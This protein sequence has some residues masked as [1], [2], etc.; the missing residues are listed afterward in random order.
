MPNQTTNSFQKL[1]SDLHVYNVGNN[2]YID[3]LN[4]EITAD[5]D[6]QFI[7]QNADGN[8]FKTGIEGKPGSREPEYV[9]V[10]CVTYRNIAYILSTN[11]LSSQIGTYP[12]PA[13][14]DI[15]DPNNKDTYFDLVDE[16]RP[17]HN[18]HAPVH[19][20]DHLVTSID[21]DYNQPFITNKLKFDL[22]DRPDLILQ[23]SYDGTMNLIFIDGDGKPRLVNSRFKLNGTGN[24]ATLGYRNNLKDTNVYSSLLF[25]KTL[26]LKS[27]TTIP[28]IDLDSVEMG[29]DLPGGSFIFY[30]RYKDGDGMET[31]VVEQTMNV[32]VSHEGHGAAGDDN[33]KKVIRLKLKNLDPTYDQVQ[34]YYEHISGDKVAASVYKKITSAYSYSY[35]DNA[36]ELF[37]TINGNETTTTVDPDTFNLR[38]SNIDKVKTLTHQ[39]DRLI[40]GNITMYGGNQDYDALR[41]ISQKIT[42][43][44]RGLSLD[45]KG[46]YKDPINNYYNLGYWEGETY[47]FCVNYVMKSG[48]V[49]EGFPVVGVDSHGFNISSAIIQELDNATGTVMQPGGFNNV[50]AY[51]IQDKRN[52]LDVDTNQMEV[53][54]LSA[55]LS[56]WKSTIDITLLDKINGIFFTRKERQR[57]CR[58]AGFLTNTIQFDPYPNVYSGDHRSGRF[59][60][61]DHKRQIDGKNEFNVGDVIGYNDQTKISHI[62]PSY[63]MWLESHNP[64]RVRQLFDE[65]INKT[66]YPAPGGMFETCIS[67][68][69][70]VSYAPGFESNYIKNL[71]TPV[72]FFMSNLGNADRAEQRTA[73]YTPELFTSQED[74]NSFFSNSNVGVDLYNN[75]IKAN[76]STLLHNNTADYQDVN[77]TSLWDIR[78]NISTGKSYSEPIGGIGTVHSSLVNELSA[79]YPNNFAGI[80]DRQKFWGME[81][82]PFVPNILT[83]AQ[84]QGF[85]DNLNNS[86]GF[87]NVFDN[88]PTDVKD[89]LNTIA[90]NYWKITGLQLVHIAYVIGYF[91]TLYLGN[92]EL[93]LGVPYGILNEVA[94]NPREFNAIWSVRDEHDLHTFFGNPDFS[95]SNYK[96]TGGSATCTKFGSYIGIRT[97]TKDKSMF[98]TLKV[99]NDSLDT[100]NYNVHNFNKSEGEVNH[101]LNSHLFNLKSASL[102]LARY[103]KIYS[104]TDK[105][106]SRS[107]WAAKYRDTEDTGY[108]QVGKRIP[109]S[110]LQDKV[111]I[112]DGDCYVNYDYKRLWYGLGALEDEGAT[113]PQEYSSANRNEGFYPKGVWMPMIAPSNDNTA[114]RT[115]EKVS[116]TENKIYGGNRPIFNDKDDIQSFRSSRQLESNGY[117]HG[118]TKSGGVIR[119]GRIDITK[120]VQGVDRRPTRVM[121]S[122]PSIQSAFENGYRDFRGLNHRDYDSDL[123]EINKLISTGGKLMAIHAKGVSVIPF[124]EKS[125]VSQDSG[126]IFVQDAQ[127]LGPKLGTVSSKI[128][129]QDKSSAITTSRFVYGYDKNR[130]SIWSYG[131]HSTNSYQVG[132]SLEIISD[133]KIKTLIRNYEGILDN[134]DTSTVITTF[135]DQKSQVS[136]TFVGIDTEL[137]D[138]NSLDAIPDALQGVLGPVRGFNVS[139]QVRLDRY[140]GQYLVNID[141]LKILTEVTITLDYIS[142]IDKSGILVKVD[143][144]TKEFVWFRGTPPLTFIYSELH[145]EW[146]TPSNKNSNIQFSLRGHTYNMDAFDDYSGIYKFSKL[147]VPCNFSGKQHRFEFEFI[148]N[149]NT[150]VQKILENMT[151]ISNEVYPDFV[152]F[153]F[154]NSTGIDT[155]ELTT[156]DYKQ[157]MK[158]RIKSLPG[159]LEFNHPPS[160]VP[161]GIVFVNFIDISEAI[162]YVDGYFTQG[163]NT[164]TI[165][166]AVVFNVGGVLKY[167][168]YIGDVNRIP[169]N[170]WTE[171]GDGS[172]TINPS[173]PLNI[174]P[175]NVNF[176]IIQENVDFVEDHL[177]IETT[178]TDTLPEVR[179]KSIRVK[180]SYPGYNKVYIQAIVSL[181]SYS[182]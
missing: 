148:V 71:G 25:H 11:G 138:I 62:V 38:L 1:N 36:G 82:S 104:G 176:G 60:I 165:T 92:G 109:V 8:V 98:N 155:N 134:Y 133:F 83:P 158:P 74:V 35:T 81:H 87:A 4:A 63:L 42:L 143:I 13:W 84:V 126:G 78:N 144:N 34:V 41:L 131:N 107:S 175:E 149:D 56:V 170:V 45:S 135:D 106:L 27:Y 108:F 21:E 172:I 86:V 95:S 101:A 117:N 121:V 28:D 14:V 47:E 151:V 80:L 2:T 43:E 128:G 39:H 96:V 139:P 89:E 113:S 161:T 110:E 6:G 54:Y 171:F 160:G 37:I 3:A 69:D 53:K 17:L 178:R 142:Y 19:T 40:L 85:T 76:T 100:G 7:F 75:I 169:V 44:T 137:L 156:S 68:I 112:F 49:T 147:A 24:K 90:S 118:Y 124:M 48:F 77:K 164:Y 91:P 102:D 15:N 132:D 116:D 94:N 67:E 52:L 29:G 115:M 122:A 66:Y 72:L 5:S 93:N 152:S 9:P 127:I 30:F 177:Y 20:L 18:M 50:G 70:A 23:E 22:R 105:P 61:D 173:Y 162:S 167:G 182:K 59:L 145:K 129:S 163:N 159:H 99:S 97:N 32:V 103:G 130:S 157:Y 154:E 166:E 51:R 58:Y 111:S 12:S 46:S 174:Q 64:N 26:L 141:E 65:G 79:S 180:F 179:D 181:I 146:L 88:L 33:T 73:F 136:F 57:D 150:S 123:G 114:L 55:N 120:P 140:T 16:Y 31:D 125:L 119:Y 168:L 153:S 10:A